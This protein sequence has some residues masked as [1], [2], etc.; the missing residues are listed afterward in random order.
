M[1][2]SIDESWFWP[3]WAVLANVNWLVRVGNEPKEKK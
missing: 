1:T 3:A 2:I